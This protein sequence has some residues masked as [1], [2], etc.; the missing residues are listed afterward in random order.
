MTISVQEPVVLLT[1]AEAAR[2]LRVSAKTLARATKAGEIQ[3]TRIGVTGRG[4]RYRLS[5]L[6]R[7]ADARSEPTG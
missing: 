3:P 5:E 6:Q 1:V 4:V 2:A 7:F